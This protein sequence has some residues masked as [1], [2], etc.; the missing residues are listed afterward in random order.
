M[1]ERRGKGKAGNAPDALR[2]AVEQTYEATAGSAAET[3][4]RAGELLEQLVGRGEEARR[5]L[6]RR[7]A[8]A[9]RSLERRGAEARNL[10]ADAISEIERKIRP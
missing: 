4:E 10:L 8:E 1:S 6:E 5:H 9:R 2:A 7:G 3:R